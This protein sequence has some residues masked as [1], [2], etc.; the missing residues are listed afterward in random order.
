M[1][2][3]KYKVPTE[4]SRKITLLMIRMCLVE[5][6]HI[7]AVPFYRGKATAMTL[8]EKTG[9]AVV[10]YNMDAG[11]DFHILEIIRFGEIPAADTLFAPVVAE[12]EQVLE[13]ADNSYSF[14]Q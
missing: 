11:D 4:K 3:I 6:E 1:T 5:N 10:T 2:T 12:F 8:T 7:K 9:A 13:P 14:A